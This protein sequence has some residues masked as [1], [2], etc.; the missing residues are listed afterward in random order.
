MVRR[1]AVASAL[2]L[3]LVLGAV[4]PAFALEG[5]SASGSSNDISYKMTDYYAYS[6]SSQAYV[7]SFQIDCSVKSK[8]T[9][10]NKYKVP[11]VY[12]MYAGAAEYGSDNN[13]KKWGGIEG[14]PG[15]NSRRNGPVWNIGALKA[16]VW[17]KTYTWNVTPLRW[18][19]VYWPWTRL[20]VTL[21]TYV[22]EEDGLG[23]QVFRYRDFSKFTLPAPVQGH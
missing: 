5:W 20:Y 14:L 21:N 9:N 10:V 15:A 13:L 3:V 23:F 16:G 8:Y 22:R 17:T 4:A 6:S 12:Y 1:M 19:D 2:A 7:R 11:Y 18:M